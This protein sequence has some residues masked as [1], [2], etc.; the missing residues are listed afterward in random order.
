MFDAQLSLVEYPEDQRHSGDHSDNSTTAALRQKQRDHDRHC[1]A[2]DR[3]CV[4]HAGAP[5]NHDCENGQQVPEVLQVIEK[6]V[7]T[8]EL[9]S[10]PRRGPA[11]LAEIVDHL[12]HVEVTWH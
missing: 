7:P 11:F 1:D 9:S 12:E 6:R 2:D 8:T 5:D 10:S 4:A 3:A